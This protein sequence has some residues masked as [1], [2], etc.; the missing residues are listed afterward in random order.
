MKASQHQTDEVDEDS[1]AA[2][3][4]RRFRIYLGAAPGV[5][6]TYA[7]LSEGHRRRR[8][9][10]DVAIGSSNVMGGRAPRS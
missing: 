4:P 7:M 8:R 3:P 6:K 9:G 10:A 2:A 5:G 1:M